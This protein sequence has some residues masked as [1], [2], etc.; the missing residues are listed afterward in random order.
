[1]KD[2]M[3]AN[4]HRRSIRHREE[5]LSSKACGC[6]YCI[7]L[8]APAEIRDWIDE[9]RGVGQTALCPHCGIDSV[10][11]DGSGFEIGEFLLRRM[12]KRFFQV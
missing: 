3:L 4:V 11:G 10:V 6:F 7:A 2:D 5:I 12:N 1:M 9:E 8:F